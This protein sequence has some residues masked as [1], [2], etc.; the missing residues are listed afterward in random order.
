MD[1]TICDMCSTDIPMDESWTC[2]GCGL[3]VCADCLDVSTG[4]DLCHECAAKSKAASQ[5]ATEE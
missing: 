5:P 2:A 4:R 3:T 1:D